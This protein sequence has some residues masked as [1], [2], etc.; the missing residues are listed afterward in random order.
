MT[1]RAKTVTST[2]VAAKEKEPDKE[3]VHN[4]N[5]SARAKGRTVAGKRV[6]ARARTAGK[7]KDRVKG[8]YCLC[9]GPDD[10]TPM[11][12]CGHCKDWYH[13]RCID[14]NEEDAEEIKVYVC[15][16]CTEKTGKHTVMEWEGPEALQVVVHGQKRENGAARAGPAKEEEEEEE[17]RKRELLVPLEASES[18]DGSEGDEY[19]DEEKKARARSKGNGKRPMRRLSTSSEAGS[20][21]SKHEG[22]KRASQSQSQARRASTA[23]GAPVPRSSSPPSR[24]GKRRQ[25]S[26]AAA[27]PSSKRPRSESTV[28]D[29][30]TRKYCLGKLTECLVAIFVRPASDDEKIAEEEE[31]RAARA[32]AYA[33]ELEQCLYDTYVESDKQG[34]QSAGAKYK[35]RFRMITFNLPQPDRAYLHRQIV[36]GTLT[37]QTLAGMSSTD[38][39]S[40]ETQE[41]IRAAEQAAL[42]QSILQKSVHPRAKIT[43]KGL[44]DIEDENA[45]LERDIVRAREDDERER[46][47]AVRLR[48]VVGAAPSTSASYP[49]PSPAEWASRHPPPAPV[50]G[51]DGASPTILNPC[52]LIHIDDEPTE[53]QALTPVAP[54]MDADHG[55]LASTSSAVPPTTGISP[56]AA[57]MPDM[58]PRASFDLSALWN[59]PTKDAGE[60]GGSVGISVGE[61][62]GEPIQRLPTPMPPTPPDVREPEGGGKDGDGD[63]RMDDG[64]VGADAEVEVGGGGDE[65]DDHDFDMFLG[66]DEDEKEG[67]NETAPIPKSPQEIFEALPSVWSGTMN[68]PLDSSIPQETHIVARQIGGRP[69]E[70]TSALWKTLFPAEALR[71]EGR[72][73]VDGSA[74]YLTHSRMNPFKELIAVAFMPTSEADADGFRSVGEFLISKDRHGLIFPWGNRGKDWGKELYV[75]PLP[76][77]QAIPEFVELLDDLRL[78]KERIAD[79]MV[80][81]WVLNKGKLAP[82]PPAHLQSPHPQPHP[83]PT[84][85]TPRNQ[86]PL[87]AFPP[88]PL[89]PLPPVLPNI[90][91]AAP[92]VPPPPVSVSQIPP[93][94]LAAEVASLTPEQIQLMLQTLQNT[95]GF[96]AAPTPQPGPSPFSPTQQQQQFTPPIQNM[97][98]PPAMPGFPSSGSPSNPLPIPNHLGHRSPSFSG[99]GPGPYPPFSD[100][101]PS[102]ESYGRGDYGERGSRGRGRGGRGRGRGYEDYRRSSDSGWSRR[103]RGRGVDSGSAERYARRGGDPSY[104]S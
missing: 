33:A 23:S 52:I 13:F 5:V 9:K 68:M 6:K 61:G 47:R 100:R 102:G 16:P 72:V 22:K 85:V 46:E 4:H 92:A 7:A 75:V 36:E 25:S 65:D 3:K 80:G 55:T 19:V 41:S 31:G 32:R 63:V 94:V 28:S 82:P 62:E 95:V 1:T 81:I 53:G 2:N 79:C 77:A 40:E 90:P 44:Q 64:M 48:A 56:F 42:A 18:S 104:W 34:R 21:H 71:I 66:R 74:Q 26:V 43:H 78:P 87:L 59:A 20:E 67:E 49:P 76:A 99:S 39:A 91:P 57:S 51:D 12:Q 27:A 11:V 37:P 10:G 60:E 54:Q 88:L 17:E 35:E 38:L 98:W 69:L 50:A 8:P 73:P 15:P 14:L 58:P 45:D 83:P 30:P 24:V 103:G 89:T 96:P 84:S 93:S 101:P 97:P 70:Q 29:D 86:N